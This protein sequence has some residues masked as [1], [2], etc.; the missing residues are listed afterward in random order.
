MV[1][2]TADGFGRAHFDENNGCF[3]DICK[4]FVLMPG[5]VLVRDLIHNV[6]KDSFFSLF[7]LLSFFPGVYSEIS[8]ANSCTEILL[9]GE[10]LFSFSIRILPVSAALTMLIALSNVRSLSRSKRA[11]SY[12]LVVNSTNDSTFIRLSCRDSNS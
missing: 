7:C 5:I 8:F 3:R 6:N 10:G 4:M 12:A 2:W 1:L 11:F 9:R